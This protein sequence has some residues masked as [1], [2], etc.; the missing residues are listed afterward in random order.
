M[1]LS[2]N[3]SQ[4]NLGSL[5]ILSRQVFSLHHFSFSCCFNFSSEMLVTAWDTPQWDTVQSSASAS[6]IFLV[7]FSLSQ[8]TGAPLEVPVLMPG[9]LGERSSNRLRSL[10]FPELCGQPQA[11]GLR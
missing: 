8:G 1:T 3:A 4:V 9:Q 11:E 6:A 7:V 10:V 5:T 2:P